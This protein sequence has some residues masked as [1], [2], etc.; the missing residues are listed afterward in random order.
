MLEQDQSKN[1]SKITRKD[2]N[3]FFKKKECWNCNNFHHKLIITKYHGIVCKKCYQALHEENNK[4][5]FNFVSAL[6]I[7]F[8]TPM[9]E[10]TKTLEV[11]IETMHNFWKVYVIESNF[12][13]NDFDK[14]YLEDIKAVK[15]A[16]EM[17]ETYNI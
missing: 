6:D 17:I 1:T 3:Y 9:N 5:F 13:L 2:L 15:E 12:D 14:C 8:D 16:Y 10:E 11:T 7:E 4:T